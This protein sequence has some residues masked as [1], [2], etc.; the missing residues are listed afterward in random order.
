VFRLKA[1]DS[2]TN[3]TRP[4]FCLAPA[5]QWRALEECWLEG[6]PWPAWKRSVEEGGRISERDRSACS[7]RA[8]PGR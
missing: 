1:R 3:L 8:L 2:V 5:R 7:A 4:V 6:Y